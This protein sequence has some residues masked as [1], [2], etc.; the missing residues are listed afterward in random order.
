[1]H[2]NQALPPALAHNG[3]QRDGNKSKLLAPL[4]A[5]NDDELAQAPQVDFKVLDGAF[6]VQM[7]SP[8]G[9]ITYSEYA[10]QVFM[11]YV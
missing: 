9:C 3:E 1:M 4:E 7:L 10:K 11:P 5:L 6:I 8:A 2:E